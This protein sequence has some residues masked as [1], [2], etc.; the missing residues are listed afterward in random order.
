MSD[1]LKIPPFVLV[2]VDAPE[3]IIALA[4]TQQQAEQTQT[5]LLESQTGIVIQDNAAGRIATKESAEPSPLQQIVAE[6]VT[7]SGSELGAHEAI[8]GLLHQPPPEEIPAAEP[9]PVVASEPVPELPKVQ[10][11]K[12]QILRDIHSGTQVVVI[13]V[14]ADLSWMIV[15]AA[16]DSYEMPVPAVSSQYYQFVRDSGTDPLPLPPPSQDDIPA[17]AVNPRATPAAARR[18]RDVKF[19]PSGPKLREK[20]RPVVM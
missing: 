19:R 20:N 8:Y 6:L 2:S 12:D 1:P 14:A 11:K 17:A 5:R 9:A 15:R 16:G 7:F 3:V 4:W 18:G 13:D 10:F